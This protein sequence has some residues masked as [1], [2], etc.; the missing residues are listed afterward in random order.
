[1]LEKQLSVVSIFNEIIMK[2]K[3]QFWPKKEHVLFHF[4]EKHVWII[5]LVD[6]PPHMLSFMKQDTM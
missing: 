5:V 4:R 2:T 6:P 3:I 1:M